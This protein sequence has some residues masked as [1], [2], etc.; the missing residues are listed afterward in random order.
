[1]KNYTNSVFID[2]IEDDSRVRFIRAEV[3]GSK[4]IRV[5][6]N[7]QGRPVYIVYPDDYFTDET[8]KSHLE[9]LGLLDLIPVLFSIAAQSQQKAYIKEG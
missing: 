8:A 6:E 2:F 5:Y 4:T 3:I 9:E 1:M 7:T